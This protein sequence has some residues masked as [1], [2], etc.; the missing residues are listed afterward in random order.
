MGHSHL[1][2]YYHQ[3]RVFFS[4]GVL[5]DILK[6]H[7]GLSNDILKSNCE[8]PWPSQRRQMEKERTKLTRLA[9][10]ERSGMEFTSKTQNGEKEVAGL[11]TTPEIML[12]RG[13]KTMGNLKKLRKL[14]HAGDSMIQAATVTAEKLQVRAG[15]KGKLECFL[16]DRGL[17]KEYP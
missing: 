16:P 4:Q 11:R 10:F 8:E 7:P 3:D 1:H 15:V 2:M 14:A 5:H 12:F 13:W 9:L 6:L 17:L